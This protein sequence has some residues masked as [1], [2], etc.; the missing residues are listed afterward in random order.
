LAYFGETLPEP[1]GNCDTCLVPVATWDGTVAAQ[2]ALSTVVRTGQRFGAGH[3][4]DVLLG[5]ETPRVRSLGHHTL[6][7]YGIGTEHS[8]RA[9]RGVL[10]QLV[11]GGYLSTDADGYGTLKLA[12]R[13]SALLKGQ[14][15]VH[16]RHDPAP[17]KTPGK[18][19]GAARPADTLSGGAAAL[20][21]ALRALRGE[22]ARAQGVPAYVI[23]DNKTLLK[24]AELKPRSLA[25]LR[26]VPGVGEV[27][28][29][30]YGEPFMAVLAR[31]E[32]ADLP[33][34]TQSATYALIKEG[35]SA[36]RVA[37]RRALTLNTVLQHCAELIAAGRLSVT[38]ATGLSEDEVR[39]I[40]T[41][42]DGLPEAAQGK[43]KPLFERLQER[44]DYGVLR[45]VLEGKR[46]K[47][48]G[49]KASH[50]EFTQS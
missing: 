1:C 48:A 25:E 44:Y 36:E 28:L 46:L 17:Q 7:T 38:E 10:R 3:V 31:H 22:L 9:W 13:S 8:E 29:A 32:P 4:I 42:Y 43:L 6:S 5:K 16:F 20:F 37:E 18:S 40:E 30:R 14:E 45:C 47:N 41:A 2:K 26:G 11:A 50:Q 23:F 12:P 35:L 24:M 39:Q 19:R 49:L 34:E 21:E 15:A 27:K 33:S